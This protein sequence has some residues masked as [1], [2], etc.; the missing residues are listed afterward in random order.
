MNSKL[1]LVAANMRDC[2]EH[3]NKK[4]RMCGWWIEMDEA[5]PLGVPS[6][7][8]VMKNTDIDKYGQYNRHLLNSFMSTMEKYKCTV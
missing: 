8:E 3:A 5:L 6:L 1:Y 2:G 7:P 4:W